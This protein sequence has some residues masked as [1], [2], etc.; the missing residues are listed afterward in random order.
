V[1]GISS[2]T[3]RVLVLNSGARE[4]QALLRWWTVIHDE[5]DDAREQG[6]QHDHP[7][8]FWRALELASYDP[9]ADAI[10]WRGMTKTIE[11]INNMERTKR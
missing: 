11:A 3:S 6:I 5:D 9:V 7:G 10:H 1:I 8:P 2:P 4:R